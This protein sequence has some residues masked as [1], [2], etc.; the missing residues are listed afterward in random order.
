MLFACD[1]PMVIFL[2]F[3]IF[4][5]MFTRC[6]SYVKTNLLILLLFYEPIK[7]QQSVLLFLERIKFPIP[8]INLVNIFTYY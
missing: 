4:A 1:I 2:I 5:T 6:S 7:L 3:H 8:V